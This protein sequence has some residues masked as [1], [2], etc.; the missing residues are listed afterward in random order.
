MNIKKLALFLGITFF[1]FFLLATATG[2][3][4]EDDV[5]AT[6]TVQNIACSVADAT[7]SYG[8]LTT[9]GSAHTAAG[10]NGETQT[11]TNDGNDN[12]DFDLKGVHT[13]TT[14]GA[15]TLAATIGVLDEYKHDYCIT[16]CDGTPTW[17]PLTT[18]Y[19]EIATGVAALGTQLFDARM[20]TPSSTSSYTVQ[21]ATIWAQCSATP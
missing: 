8:F 19:A 14:G 3:L 21:N 10:G 20:N 17:V 11:I 5:A 12:V 16:D 15:W 1:S 4:T 2:A 13:T 6:V 7:I 18:S 9:S